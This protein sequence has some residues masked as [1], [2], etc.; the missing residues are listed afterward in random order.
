MYKIRIKY[1]RIIKERRAMLAKIQKFWRKMRMMKLI[2]MAMKHKK[3]K[4]A[5]EI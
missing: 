2:P 5:V 4:A 1:S 3:D